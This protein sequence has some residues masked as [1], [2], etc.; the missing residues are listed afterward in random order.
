MIIFRPKVFSSPEDN[1]QKKG[2]LT[3]AIIAANERSQMALQRT[4]LVSQRSQQEE[5]MKQQRLNM[6]SARMS[7][8]NILHES[9]AKQRQTMQNQR[10][11]VQKQLAAERNLARLKS[12]EKISIVKNV[13]LYKR[14][15]TSVP[16]VPMDN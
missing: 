14:P 6:I 15:S 3:P 13:H 9:R 5:G 16:P 1:T 4:N 10:L 11:A 7:Q 8:Q 12:A 2:Q